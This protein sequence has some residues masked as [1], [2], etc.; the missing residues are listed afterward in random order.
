MV[1]PLYP[2][3]LVVVACQHFQQFIPSLC[4]CVINMVY[5]YTKLDS[6]WKYKAGLSKVV[7]CYFRWIRYSQ[8]IE[9]QTCSHVA[10]W[11]TYLSFSEF[12]ANQN[13]VLDA[14]VDS[15]LPKY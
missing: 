5:V 9:K 10:H 11:F 3:E 4:I 15:V 12:P 7:G 1:T 14:Q 8:N 6:P 13:F 2:D